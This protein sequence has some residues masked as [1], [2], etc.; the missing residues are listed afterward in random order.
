MIDPFQDFLPARAGI[1]GEIAAH[2]ENVLPAFSG[3]SLGRVAQR[4]VHRQ[5]A[6]TDDFEWNQ[7]DGENCDNPNRERNI[8]LQQVKFIL[9]RQ[10]FGQISVGINPAVTQERPV[11]AGDVHMGQVD[12]R[13]QNLFLVGT[14]LGDDFTRCAGD[15]T[16]S[17]EFY[18]IAADAIEN[19]QADAIRHGDITAVGHGMCAL[20]GFPGTVLF[21]AVFFLFSGMPADG[22]RIKK[23]FRALH[24]SQTRGF[25]IPLIPA[26]QHTDLRIFGL[27]GLETE[28][29]GRKIKFFVKQRIVGNVHLAIYAQQRTVRV[30]DGGR[31]V[32]NSGGPLFEKRGDND[33]LEFF[34][35]LEESISARPG[36]FFRKLEILVVLALAKIL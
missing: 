31:V 16:L 25:R 13:D 7:D 9:I 24:G 2:Y 14:G 12:R 33:D 11:G 34:C 26:Y 21:D 5:K 8:T 19:L 28:I 17:P 29:A 27:P 4:I 22:R 23:D 20:N 36:D 3:N 32:I 18:A 1:D 10:A 15:K 35:Q 6:E 30:D